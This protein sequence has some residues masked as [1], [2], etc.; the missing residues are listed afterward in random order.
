MCVLKEKMNEQVNKFYDITDN[1]YKYY[2]IHGI[3]LYF[4]C[5]D[6]ALRDELIGLEILIPNNSNEIKENVIERG[7]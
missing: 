5:Y 3:G 4:N 2:S 1:C 7:N 6:D